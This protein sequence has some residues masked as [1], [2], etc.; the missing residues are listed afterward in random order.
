MTGQ[1]R[2]GIGV[3]IPHIILHRFT[4]RI[5]EQ[6]RVFCIVSGNMQ[7]HN[8]RQIDAVNKGPRRDMPMIDGIHINI[9]D[10]K[11]NI[12]VCLTCYGIKEIYLVHLAMRGMQIVRSVF[13][14]DPLS[15]EILRLPDTGGSM[16]DVFSRECQRQ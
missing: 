2:T 8:A 5:D 12:A 7:I 6:A 3:H 4:V 11:M 9:I 15:K 10:I 1:A 16:A 13:D 14:S